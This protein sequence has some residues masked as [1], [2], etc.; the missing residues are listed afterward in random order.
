MALRAGENYAFVIGYARDPLRFKPLTL[1]DLFKPRGVKRH[2][3]DVADIFSLKHWYF[4]IDN[5][6]SRNDAHKQ[7][8]NLA[9]LG[10]EYPLRC[11][12]I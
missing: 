3:Q 4:N 12:T 8:R 2:D 7:I 6:L 11:L 1:Q 10:V 5:W 9:L